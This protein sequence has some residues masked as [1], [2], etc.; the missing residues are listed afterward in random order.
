VNSVSA[1]TGATDL[2]FRKA[3]TNAIF[4]AVSDLTDLGIS[5]P[6]KISPNARAIDGLDRTAE[7]DVHGRM[8]QLADEQ[9]ETSKI[10]LEDI[11]FV[12]VSVDL[13]TLH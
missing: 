2:S 12:D 9:L 11:H 6:Q 5:I 10:Q 4:K 13:V 3:V 8:A 7:N 1:F